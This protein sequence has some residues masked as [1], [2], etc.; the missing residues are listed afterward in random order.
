[1]FSFPDGFAS[2]TLGVMGNMVVSLTPVIT[3][4]VGVLLAVVAT[5]YLIRVLTHQ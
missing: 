3:V 5:T 1:M 2:S 4:V